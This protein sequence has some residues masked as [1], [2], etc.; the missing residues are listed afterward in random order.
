MTD[1]EHASGQRA[2]GRRRRALRF[3]TS[4]WSLTVLLWLLVANIFA[5]PLAHFATWGRLA[6][7]GVF[8]LIIISGVIATARNRRFVAVTTAFILVFLFVGWE[9]IERPT[10]YLGV[11]NDLG[12]L[13]FLGFFAVLL[14]RQV[15]R[16][17]SITW[18]RV[19]GAVAVYLLMGLLWAFAYDIVELLQPGS[20]GLK[21][22]GSGGAL[23]ELGYFSFTTLTTLGF[24]DILPVSP[25]ARSLA[26]LEGLVGQLF[27]VILIARLGAM[28]LEYQRNRAVC[29]RVIRCKTHV[30]K[31][32][33][34]R[35]LEALLY[36]NDGAIPGNHKSSIH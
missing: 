24:G 13:L 32:F 25:L 33:L 3:W 15:L 28:E 19:E 34:T 10:L 6:A 1:K 26:V 11:L 17:G 36:P 21:T 2:P 14:L 12:A 22:Q 31:T 29:V 9:G 27:P 16:A 35:I 5:Q 8:S 30:T 20:F 4:D 18:H 23:P 7:R